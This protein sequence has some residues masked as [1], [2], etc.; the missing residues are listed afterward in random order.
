MANLPETRPARSKPRTFRGVALRGLTFL[1]PPILT[2]VILVWVVSTIDSYVLEP[3]T[4][5]ARKAL[6]W[7]ISDVREGKPGSAAAGTIKLIDGR[8]YTRL[9]SG[10]YVPSEIADWWRKNRADERLPASGQEVYQGYVEARFLRPQIVIPVFLCLFV[11]FLYVLG[12]FLASEIGGLF[13][14]GILRL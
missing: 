5:A 1:L 3:V 12:K 8:S 13:D 9:A 10:E 2:V 6:A 11:L 7:S 4:V 14:W